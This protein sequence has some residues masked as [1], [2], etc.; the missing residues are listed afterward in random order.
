MSHILL[1]SIKIYGNKYLGILIDYK[2]KN[3]N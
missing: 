1:H 2:F 3:C